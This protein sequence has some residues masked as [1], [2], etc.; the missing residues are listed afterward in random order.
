MIYKRGHEF[1]KP[2]ASL[3]LRPNEKINLVKM[4]KIK[5]QIIAPRIVKIFEGYHT[6]LDKFAKDDVA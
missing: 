4:Y 3:R 1:Y 2:C 6:F 5:H